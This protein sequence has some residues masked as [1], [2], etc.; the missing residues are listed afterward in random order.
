[1]QHPLTKCLSRSC[2]ASKCL[3]SAQLLHMWAHSW[4]SW[5]NTNETSLHYQLCWK[6]YSNDNRLWLTAMTWLSH[7]LLRP[8]QGCMHLHPSSCWIPNC[9]YKATL[10][11][12]GLWFISHFIETEFLA[13]YFISPRWTLALIISAKWEVALTSMW[14]CVKLQNR[15]YYVI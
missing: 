3:Q 4:K 15:L 5:S 2:F 13:A 11:H 14:L 8:E 6:L 1:M 7:W 10:Y 12:E 9:S